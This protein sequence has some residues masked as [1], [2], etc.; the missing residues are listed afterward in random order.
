MEFTVAIFF[1]VPLI[2]FGLF[3]L[4][5]ILWG[6]YIVIS[7]ILLIFGIDINPYEI[8][9]SKYDDPDFGQGND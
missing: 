8:D 4:G 5:L 1:W 7:L 3:V 9:T 2:L 6:I